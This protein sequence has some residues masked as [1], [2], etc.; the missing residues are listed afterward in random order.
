MRTRSP[1]LSILL[2]VLACLAYRGA[3]A[4]DF[5][6]YRLTDLY[7]DASGCTGDQGACG[8]VGTI[9]RFITVTTGNDCTLPDLGSGSV[10]YIINAGAGRLSVWPAPGEGAGAGSDT[11]FTLYPGYAATCFGVTPSDWQCSSSPTIPLAAAAPGSGVTTNGSVYWGSTDA[12]YDTG[13]E[14]CVS[15][16]LTCR[17]TLS[18]TDPVTTPAC[19]ATHTTPFQAGCY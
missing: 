6:Q 17:A 2:L 18:W 12:A 19:G 7:R 10:I 8:I 4:E 16:G 15:H 5:I 9:T 3:T 14:V 11:A 13:T 1:G